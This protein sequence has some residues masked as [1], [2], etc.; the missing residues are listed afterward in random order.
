MWRVDGMSSNNVY[1]TL[2][3]TSEAL[4]VMMIVVI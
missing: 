3:S 4:E 2:V 1:M